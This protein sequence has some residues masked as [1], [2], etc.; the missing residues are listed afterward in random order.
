LR[1]LYLMLQVVLVFYLLVFTVCGVCKWYVFVCGLSS[2]S[3]Y[4]R[5]FLLVF[6]VVS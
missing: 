2:S 5:S 6:L 1:T 3:F 4:A